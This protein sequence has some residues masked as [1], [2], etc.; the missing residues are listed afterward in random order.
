MQKSILRCH[1]VLKLCQ[2]RGY[3]GCDRRP[4]MPTECKM[5]YCWGKAHKKHG[6]FTAAEHSASRA[7]LLT[8]MHGQNSQNG[9][10]VTGRTWVVRG[11]AHLCRVLY[12]FNPQPQVHWQGNF[13]PVSGSW[14]PNLRV[15][16]SHQT[17]CYSFPVSGYH[18]TGCNKRGGGKE[19]IGNSATSGSDLNSCPIMNWNSWK[20]VF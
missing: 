16:L 8:M 18:H 2:L 4:T 12:P 10:R 5:H 20:T 17:S 13:A 11:E 1:S 19:K 9:S 7:I 14:Q 15:P 6:P 3:T